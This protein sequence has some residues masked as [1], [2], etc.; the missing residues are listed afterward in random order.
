M[1]ILNKNF[2]CII[3]GQVVSLFGNALLRFALPLYIL[4]K[5]GNPAIFGMV[6][7]LSIIPTILCAPIGGLVADRINKKWIMVVLDVITTIII[8]GF[9]LI[10]KDISNQLVLISVMLI[11]LSIIQSFYQP[12]VQSSVP[13][14]LDK[15]DIVKGNASV[16]GINSLANLIGPLLGG[17]LY[18][19]FSLDAILIGS[20][21]CFSIAVIIELFIKMPHVKQENK[22][23]IFSMIRSDIS[24]STSFLFKENRTILNVAL[25][26]TFINLILSA[27]IIVGYPIFI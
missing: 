14:V 9:F 17:I 8:S 26:A 12:A 18:G 11:L 21:I 23:N 24:E 5:T 20:I 27:L 13:L 10:Y 16:S 15:E 6:L 1:K 22:G 25:L 2:I 7:A 3:L 4:D 19:F